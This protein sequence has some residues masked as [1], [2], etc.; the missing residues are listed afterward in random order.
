MKA[1]ALAFAAAF[2]LARPCDAVEKAGSTAAPVLQVPMGSRA[3]G[4]GSAFTAV[5][6]DVSALYYNPAGLSRLNAQEAAFTYISGLS[7]NNLQQIAYGGPLPFSGISGNGYASAGGSLLLA[8]DGTIEVNRTNPDGSF[9]STQNLSAGSDLVATGGYAERVGTTP[10]DVK[11]TSY[12]INHFIG[13]TGKFV[14][15][16]LVQQY[17]AHAFTAD[18]GYLVNSPEAGLSFGLSALNIGGQLKYADVGDPLPTT[19]RSGLAYQGSPS[20]SQVVTFATDAE[21]LVN[22]QTW[23]VNAGLEYF[24]AKT[25]G[26][27]IGYQFMQDA[28]GL[29][30]GFGFRWRS[31]VLI[32]YAWVNSGALSDSHRFTISYRFGGVTPAVRGRPRRPYIEALPEK[33]QRDIDEETPPAPPAPRPR[34]ASREEHPGGVSGWIY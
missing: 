30:A 20:E 11:E 8:Q 3:I 18:V 6:S 28:I 27:R 14:R 2:W 16:T 32:D 1:R 7:D 12:G 17:S 22:E 4:M 23:H 33:E 21:Y 25:Y 26:F 24:L 19:L 34:P 13:I 9:L 10:L 5:A 29:T 31:R 15:S